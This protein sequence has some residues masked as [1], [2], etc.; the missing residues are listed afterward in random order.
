[1]PWVDYRYREVYD[2]TFAYYRAA[3]RTGQWDRHVHE[4]YTARREGTIP[5]PPACAAR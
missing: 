3:G 4:L 2:P 5:R 1:M